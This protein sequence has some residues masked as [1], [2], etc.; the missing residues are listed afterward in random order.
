MTKDKSQQATNREVKDTGEPGTGGDRK[1]EQGKATKLPPGDPRAA[2]EKAEARPDQV[3]QDNAN[4]KDD[5][6][7]AS[8]PKP[9]D[10]PRRIRAA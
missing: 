8:K 4:P 3:T 5:A 9:Q 2:T 7:P 10:N 1:N 6:N